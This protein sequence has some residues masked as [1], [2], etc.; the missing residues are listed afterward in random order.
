MVQLSANL[1]S[2]RARDYSPTTGQFLSNDPSGLVGG[3]SNIRR[4]SANDPI[5]TGDPS[6]LGQFVYFVGNTIAAGP[7][8]NTVFGNWAAMT[9]TVASNAVGGAFAP[10]HEGYLTDDGRV[11]SI[12]G[13]PQDASGSNV[14]YHVDTAANVRQQG[15]DLVALDQNNYNDASVLAGFQAIGQNVQAGNQSWWVLPVA[16]NTFNCQSVSNDIRSQYAQVQ[17]SEDPNALVGPAG[18]GVPNYIQGG[19]ALPY[20]VDFANDGNA[21]A[22]DVSVSEQLDANLDWSTFQ[23]GSFGFGPIFITVPGGLTDYQTTVSYQ[24]TDGSALNVLVSLHF[25][26]A[27]GLLTATFTSLDPLTG[28]AP[29]GVFDGFLP[30]DDSTRIGEG[31]VQYTVQAKSG[32]STGTAVNAQAAVVF[33]IN[34]PLDTAQITNTI[35]AGAPTSSVGVLPATENSTSFTVSWSG[36][37]DD[38]GSGIASYDVYV[39][40][41]SGPYTLLEIRDDVSLDHV[42]RHRWSYLL[43]L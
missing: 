28:Q 18:F 30:P 33:D 14:G 7:N 15:T 29:L 11:V 2:L 5:G 25:S 13:G 32:L 3:D 16:P 1:F 38:G 26:I 42:Q 22:L 4:Y 9:A 12:N 21:A 17:N 37:D 41:N 39:S 31:Y 23:L 20:T 35:D 24:N 8:P 19:G 36:T 27:T 6:G 43:V 10:F 40:D 34:A